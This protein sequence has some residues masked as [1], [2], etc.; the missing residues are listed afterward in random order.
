MKF[1]KGTSLLL[2]LLVMVSH[3][4]LAVNVHYCGG[5][6]AGISTA[7]NLSDISTDDFQSV[8]KSC[9]MT[10]AG[11]KGC[12]DNKLVKVDKKTDSQ[13]VVKTFSLQLEAPFLA[14][15]WKPIVFGS[16]PQ[17]TPSQ[18]AAYYCEAHAPPLYQLYSQYI[19]YA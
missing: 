17:T 11:E 2:A 16:V 8:E 3:I 1:K 4:G 15:S 9:C 19:F 5:Q 10:E 6:I 7:Y 12:C 18:P 13:T 14:E